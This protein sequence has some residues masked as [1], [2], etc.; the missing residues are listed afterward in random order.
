MAV[1][2]TTKITVTNLARRIADM[3]VT[4]TET[5]IDPETS[6][7]VV[8]PPWSK[9]YQKRRFEQDGKTVPEIRAEYEAEYRADHAASG[10]TA[11]LKA[12]I[13]KQ[14]A[15][16]NSELDALEAE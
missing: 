3:A 1:A 12:Q 7:E 11:A 13:T 16:F 9:T 4:R 5:V 2:W 8:L 10:A 6:E 15:L 14:E